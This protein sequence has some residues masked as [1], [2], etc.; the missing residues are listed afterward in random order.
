VKNIRRIL[1]AVKDADAKTLPAV[2]KAVQLARAFGADLELFHGITERLSA[3]AAYLRTGGLVG[4]ERALRTRYRNKLEALAQRLRES[5]LKVNA[6]TEWDFPV[7]EAIVRQ[8]R[9]VKADLIVAE[10]HAGRRLAPWLLHITDWELL[11]TS[12]VPVLLVKNAKAYRHPVVL[13]AIDPGHAFAKP[14][15]LDDAILGSAEQFTK[16]LGGSLHA[17]YS[18]NAIPVAVGPMNG[19]GAVVALEAIA[20][21]RERARKSFARAANGKV[22]RSR[23]HL[24]SDVPIDAILGTAK[25]TDAALVVMGAISR[26]GLKRVLIGNTAEQVL[27]QL[28]CD[29]LVVKPASFVSR[30]S[31][32]GRGVRITASPMFPSPY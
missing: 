5:G 23:R 25:E 10:C 28:T 26:S 2:D 30:V 13:A 18:Y 20:E 7:Y 32:V 6:T 11:R 3:D 21:L 31:R 27:N 12:P 1:V 15:K 4:A 16:A 22:P 17:L 14:A 8:A 29:V 24:V 9:R 19:G